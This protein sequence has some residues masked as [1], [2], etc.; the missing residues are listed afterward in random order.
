MKP[1]LASIYR[2]PHCSSS[3]LLRLHALYSAA[4]APPL[5]RTAH[6][7]PPLAIVLPAFCP[8][9]LTYCVAKPDAQSS[10]QATRCRYTLHSACRAGERRS[11]EVEGRR[12]IVLSADGDGTGAMGRAACQACS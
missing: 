5:A 7:T 6:S 9:L 11:D 8:P 2:S 10:T 4:R 3:L 1:S 12:R